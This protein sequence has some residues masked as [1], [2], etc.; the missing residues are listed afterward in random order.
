MHLETIRCQIYSEHCNFCHGCRPFRSVAVNTTVLAHFD[1]VWGGRQPPHL[2]RK[3]RVIYTE[4]RLSSFDAGPE[5]VLHLIGGQPTFQPSRASG[6][7]PAHPR[8]RSE[9]RR[10]GK[11]CGRTWRSRWWPK[12]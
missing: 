7:S 2:L 8:L 9:E 4:P 12:Q 6:P 11:E 3:R 5:P 10:V 1:A